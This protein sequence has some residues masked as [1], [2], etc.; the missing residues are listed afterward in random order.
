VTVAS[1]ASVAARDRKVAIRSALVLGASL[2]A[3]WTVGLLVRLYLPKVLGPSR[4]GTYS[5]AESFPVAAFGFLGL[6]VETYI[7]KEIPVRPEH[8]SDF[9]GGVVAV[10]AVLSTVLLAA[11][12]LVLERSGRS[13]E[14]QIVVFVFGLAQFFAQCNGTLASLLQAT[15]AVNGLALVNVV[16]KVLWGVGAL[17]AILLQLP[18][19]AIAASF[20]VSELLK[21]LVLY[22]LARRH[23][24]LETRVDLTAVRRVVVACLPYYVNAVAITIY[25]KIDVSI[26]NFVSNEEETGWY[27]AAQSLAG[28]AMLLAPLMGSVL[29]PLLSR[30]ASRSD[31][32]LRTTLLRTIET[33]M[34]MTIPVSLVM[35]IGADVAVRY[36]LG[37]RF[38]PATASVA[39]LAPM[40]VLTYLAMIFS[41]FFFLKGRPWVVT[42]VSLSALAADLIGDVLLV[43]HTHRWF[44]AGGA[45]LGASIVL[46]ATEVV[47]VAVL[48][49]II[50]WR[51]CFDRKSLRV[52]GASL[53]VALVVA[54]VDRAIAGL[55]PL[56]LVVDSALYLLL[57]SATG[58]LDVRRVLREVIAARRAG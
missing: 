7:Q 44:G 19:A 42:T 4:F 3:T 31:D 49:Q 34:S 54:A 15:R 45:G 53:L 28:I 1:V 18:L 52:I 16:G 23:L 58:A 22:R 51:N 41:I 50:G 55:G 56:R 33:I 8:A 24:D 5:F 36:A 17:C 29:M 27:G 47:V 20:G 13:G 30:V 37:A 35:C 9:F 26:V 57:A 25:A 21:T 39:I 43:P 46:V 10:R 6:G 11:I 2:V 32:E 38:V 12:A 14:V 48:G 40:F